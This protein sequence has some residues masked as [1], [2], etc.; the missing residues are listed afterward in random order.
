M[1]QYT[2]FGFKGSGSAAVE[3]ALDVSGAPYRLVEAASWA[4]SSALAELEALNPLKQI[5]TLQLPDGKVLTESAAIL[6]HLGLAFPASGILPADPWQR[7]QAIRG[8][9]FIAANCYSA[10]SIIDYPERWY[11]HVDDA[12]KALLRQGTRQRLHLHWEMF[13]DQFFAQPFLSG[14]L[15]GGLDFLAAVVSKWSGSRAHLREAR[16]DFFAT[17]E[18]I[19]QYPQVAQVFARHWNPQTNPV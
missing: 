9:V 5:P 14:A 12:A 15:P 10:I 19:E 3:A 11:A 18:R 17:L 1:P 6:I 8:L 2:L 16:P 13:A 7:A 4:P